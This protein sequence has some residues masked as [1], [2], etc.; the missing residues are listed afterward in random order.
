[1]NRNFAFALVLGFAAAGNVLADDITVD[2]HTFVSTA[3]PAQVQ[4]ELRQFRASGQSWG[5]D[6]RPAPQAASGITR[7]QV[8]G[9]FLDS[10]NTVSS[11]T[12]EDSGSMFM[13]SL[14][15]A[16]RDVEVAYWD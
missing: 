2:P 8:I 14:Q 6:H 11:S 15:P 16:R 9:E 7:A 5:D 4:E 1:M 13:G 3:D 10:R 12:G